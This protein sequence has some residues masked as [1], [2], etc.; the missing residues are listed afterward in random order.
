MA[1][2]VD[3]GVAS[4]GHRENTF[5]ED[6]FFCGVGS[7]PHKEYGTSY[8]FDFAGGTRGLDEELKAEYDSTAVFKALN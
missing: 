1:L 4:R 5:K 6:F 8:V 2:I 3:D 7:A